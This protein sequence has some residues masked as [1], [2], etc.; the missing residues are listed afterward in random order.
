MGDL[1]KKHEVSISPVVKLI[2]SAF[3][4]FRGLRHSPVLFVASFGLLYGMF[5]WILTGS[6]PLRVVNQCIHFLTVGQTDFAA[7]LLNWTGENTKNL[8]TVLMGSHF[9][10]DVNDGCNGM[11]AVTLL[12]AGLLSFPASSRHRALGALILIPVVFAVNTIRIGGLY[13]AGAHRPELFNILHVYV[14]QVIV[15]M[16]TATLWGSWLIWSTSGKRQSSSPL[17]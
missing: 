12:L 1:L 16:V 8:G 10:C 3:A 13:L 5:F 4:H 14:G 17:R 2:N 6:G 9:S 15:I 11:S 7:K